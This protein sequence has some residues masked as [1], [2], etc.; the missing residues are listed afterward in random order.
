MDQKQVDAVGPDHRV[1]LTN[2]GRAQGYRAGCALRERYGA[3]DV[4]IHSGYERTYQTALAML[5][6]YPAVECG[7]I[8]LKEKLLFREREPGYTYRHTKDEVKQFFPY[9]QGYWDLLG[10]L[11][12]RP[13]GGESLQNLIEGR[14]GAGMAEINRDYAGKRV[15]LV[16]HGRVIQCLRIMLDGLCL[17]DA[18]EFLIDKENHP[19][20]CSLTRYW[21]DPSKGKL[22]LIDWNHPVRM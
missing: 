5:E 1:K 6:A 2:I 18:E 20:N 9:L 3:P 17:E 22:V 7:M 10:P 4:V 21:Y 11:L 16:V 12:A 13:V 19:T 8:P 14:L 15:F